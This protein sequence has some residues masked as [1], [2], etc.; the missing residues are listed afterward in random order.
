MS[1]GRKKVPTLGE[2][3]WEVRQLNLPGSRVELRGG[4][5][6]IFYFSV[7][8]GHYSRFYQCTL[9]IKN[10]DPFPTL[11]VRSPNLQ[12]LSG[13]RFIPHTYPYEGKGT[14]L[15][16]WWPSG[17]EWNPHMKLRETYI[18]WTVEWLGYFEDWLATGI[19]EGGGMHPGDASTTS[20]EAHPDITD[21]NYR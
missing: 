19:W 2:R 12:E 13:D 4:R 8:P 20:L 3:S 18:A 16:L 15:C 5:E 21:R 7:S 1:F 11:I 10:G 6:L 14:N 17:Q 9:H